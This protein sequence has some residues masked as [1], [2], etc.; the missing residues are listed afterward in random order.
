VIHGHG[1]EIW[2]VSFH[3]RQNLLATASWD[4]TARLWDPDTG[5]EVHVFSD[6]AFEYRFVEFA[7]SANARLYRIH[8][9]DLMRIA[10]QRV[11]RKLTPQERAEYLHIGASAGLATD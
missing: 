4:R 1:D 5:K 8:L 7:P 6:K 11:P 10:R 9:E 3:P 2:S